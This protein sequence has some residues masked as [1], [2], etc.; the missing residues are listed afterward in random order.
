MSGESTEY[1]TNI[2]PIVTQGT[3]IGQTREPI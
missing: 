3:S 2:E 1:F